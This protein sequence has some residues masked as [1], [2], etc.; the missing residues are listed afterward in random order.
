MFRLQTRMRQQLHA[1]IWVYA[2]MLLAW[3]LPQKRAELLES[4]SGEIF[5]NPTLPAMLDLLASSPI[6]VFWVSCVTHTADRRPIG[7]AR[8]CA[9]C[10][11]VSESAADFCV[12]CSGR[13]V[14]EDLNSEGRPEGTVSVAIFDATKEGD[15]EGSETL[16]P[17]T[18]SFYNNPTQSLLA[19]D[20]ALD[21]QTDHLLLLGNQGTGKNKIIDA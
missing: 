1:H 20:L 21:L 7:V 12:S 18:G 15:A 19:R 17:S 13:L 5:S 4:T 16:I 2:D 10:S 9:I 8:T 11:E 3:E 6:G 14:F